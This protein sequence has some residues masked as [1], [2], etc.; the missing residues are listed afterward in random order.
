MDLSIMAF[1][2]STERL[3]SDRSAVTRVIEILRSKEQRGGRTE[4]RK[5]SLITSAS[6]AA[7][8]PRRTSCDEAV[9]TKNKSPS[10][11]LIDRET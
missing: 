3:A 9:L 1:L 7:L 5:E 8:L 11:R 2:F 10:L 6:A 4:G